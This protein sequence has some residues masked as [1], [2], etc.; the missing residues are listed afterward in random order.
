LKRSVLYNVFFRSVKE[1][2][3]AVAAFI[4]RINKNPMETVNRFCVRL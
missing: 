2:I 4:E 3:A 1:I